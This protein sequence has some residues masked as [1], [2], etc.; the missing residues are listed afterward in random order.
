M[1]NNLSNADLNKNN[2]FANAL[3]SGYIEKKDVNGNYL[4]HTYSS[5]FQEIKSDC[6]SGK[7]L[8]MYVNILLF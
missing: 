8:I 7:L 6:I 2:N 5:N 3:S 4:K 1:E